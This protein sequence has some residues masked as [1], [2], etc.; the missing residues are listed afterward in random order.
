VQRGGGA[1]Q[2]IQ[3]APLSCPTPEGAGNVPVNE[4][5]LK[6]EDTLRLNEIAQKGDSSSPERHSSFAMEDIKKR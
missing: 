4:Q 1:L 3:K 6:K 5:G 2:K